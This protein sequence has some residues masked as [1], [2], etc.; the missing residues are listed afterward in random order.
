MSNFIN[1]RIL[2]NILRKTKKRF[3]CMTNISGNNCRGEGTDSTTLSKCDMV[4]KM[5]IHDTLALC[6]EWNIDNEKGKK[7]RRHDRA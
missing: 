2:L 6:K 3:Q 4:V 7:S 1:V 5:R